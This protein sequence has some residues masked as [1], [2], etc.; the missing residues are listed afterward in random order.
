M[1]FAHTSAIVSIDCSAFGL[2]VDQISPHTELV[3]S[4]ALYRRRN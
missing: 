3:K 1:A 2:R 4:E